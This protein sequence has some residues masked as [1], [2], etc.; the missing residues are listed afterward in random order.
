MLEGS[1]PS[2]G[3]FVRVNQQEFLG[4]CYVVKFKIMQICWYL[5]TLQKAY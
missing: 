3:Q 2:Y 4:L 5:V 1:P